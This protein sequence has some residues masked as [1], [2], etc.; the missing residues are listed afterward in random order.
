MPTNGQRIS[1]NN[2]VHKLE[3]LDIA[4]SQPQRML[5]P[6][7]CKPIDTAMFSR[8]PRRGYTSGTPRFTWEKVHTFP[9]V[10]NAICLTF[11][12]DSLHRR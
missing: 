12:L 9:A 8:T 1:D 11:F 2:L 10:G 4:E 7:R 5:P 3:H 6:L